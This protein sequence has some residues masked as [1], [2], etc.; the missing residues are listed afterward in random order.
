M[1]LFGGDSRRDRKVR[2]IDYETGLSFNRGPMETRDEK[3]KMKI[4]GDFSGFIILFF[5][6][7]CLFVF[8]IRRSNK[9]KAVGAGVPDS[10]CI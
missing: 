2:T 8:C 5:V 10:A 1:K 7:F 3:K 9:K 4:V 6:F